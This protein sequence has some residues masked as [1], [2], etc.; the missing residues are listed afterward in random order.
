ME[1]FELVEEI[2][3]DALEQSQSARSRYVE[4][5]CAGDRRLQQ[6]VMVLLNADGDSESFLSQ[7]SENLYPLIDQALTNQIPQQQIEH[8]RLLECIG[9]GGMGVV[10][11][12]FDEKLQRHVAIKFLSSLRA[13][14][15]NDKQRF[16]N[17]AMAAARLNHA[18]VCEV[19]EIGE[20]EDGQLFI[21]TA[22]CEGK[23]LAELIQSNSLNLGQIVN[24][25]LQLCDA[26]ST[27]HNKGIYHRDLKPANVIVSDTMQV[28]L[29]DFGI[30]KIAGSDISQTGQIIGTFAY[31]SPEQFSGSMIDQRADIWSLGILL[32]ELLSG[33]TPYRG[34]NAAEIMYQIFNGASPQLGDSGLNTSGLSESEFPQLDRFKQVISRCLQL[35]KQRRFHSCEL[36]LTETNVILRGLR[37]VQH[38]EYLPVYVKTKS[39]TENTSSK[40]LSEYRKVVAMGIRLT[41]DCEYDKQKIKLTLKKFNG[42]VSHHRD[43]CMYTYFGYPK[44][45]E[46]A[47]DSAIACALRLVNL[48]GDKQG[49]GNSKTHTP[50]VSAIAIHNA[51]VVIHDDLK[52]GSKQLSGDIPGAVLPLLDINSPKPIIISASANNRLRKPLPENTIW[53]EKKYQDEALFLLDLDYNEHELVQ[54]HVQYQ[55]QLMGRYHELGLLESAWRDTLEDES[56]GIMITGDAGIGKS[57]LVHELQNSLTMKS[58]YKLLECACDPNH[59]DTALYPIIQG[60][61]S[62]VLSQEKNGDSNTSSN[63]ISRSS[64]KTFFESIRIDEEE[65]INTWS[66]LL[67]LTAD[68]PENLDLQQSPESLKNQSYRSAELLL[69]KLC[70]VS[71]TLF[72]FEDLHWADASTLEWLD[73]LLSSPLPP[74][75]MLILTGRP[76]LFNRWRSYSNLTQLALRNLGKV[77]SKDLIHDLSGNTKLNDESEQLILAKTAGNPLFIEE[78][79]KMLLGKDQFETSESKQFETPESLEDILHSRLDY[80]GGSKIIAQTASVMGR[81]FR[82]DLLS[83]LLPSHPSSIAQELV[84]LTESDILFKSDDS[85]YTF[86]HALIRDALYS[87]LPPAQQNPLHHNLAKVLCD[88]SGQDNSENENAEQIATHFSLAKEFL[89]ASEWW[90]VAAKNAQRNYAI[91]ETIRLC[92]RGLSD[93]AFMKK[94][95]GADKLELD[96]QMIL[97]PAFSASNG[98]ADEDAGKAHSRALALGE[99]LHCVETTFPS[100]VGLW[101]HHCVRAQHMQAAELARTMTDLAKRENSDDLKVEAHMA[102]GATAMFCGQ[103]QNA[104]SELDKALTLYTSEMSQTH[105]RTYGQDPAVVICS[106]Y[107]IVEEVLGNQE[108]ALQL[109]CDA[110]EIARKANHPLSLSFALGFAVHI[111]IRQQQFDIAKEL[112]EENRK[113]C[114]QHRTFVFQLLG[115]VQEGI[116][117]LSEGSTT[118]GIKVLHKSILAYK[119]MGT[120]I[121]LGTWSGM[122]A[123]SYLKLGKIDLAQQHLSEGLHQVKKSGELLSQGFLDFAAE[124]IEIVEKGLRK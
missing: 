8:Y 109:S 36:L 15:E 63:T 56:R 101:A 54:R 90:L 35:D 13:N 94:S 75:L 82:V 76:E 62:L 69:K 79:V 83:A 123:L 119:A 41:D 7:L 108:K 120:E 84:K 26:L 33:Q 106:F 34:D 97:A 86:K 47:A 55:S 102:C 72:V 87:S 68:N 124:Q 96:F 42:V 14:K 21:V 95:T 4:I 118:D 57:R 122:L 43:G 78:Y 70:L 45:G 32:F 6:Q 27:A 10:H 40:T 115:A 60:F 31:M 39:K 67:G 61:K 23:N 112:I 85:E 38:L 113:L 52:T 29:V 5:R 1:Q 71:P 93:T 28:K 100:M 18:N 12:A 48:D 105:I 58:Q 59:Q 111:R 3:S 37:D 80:L 81:T 50:L 20:T 9:E 24:I 66:W 107:A 104:K 46:G 103:I 88:F 114:D 65:N 77:D 116:L 11:K 92:K 74:Q 64:I 117:L 121:F 110:V 22:F 19:F 16:I 44:L 25:M 2:F 89:S 30:A 53:A 17:E 49:P 99:K 51:P 91:V 73:T 98:Y